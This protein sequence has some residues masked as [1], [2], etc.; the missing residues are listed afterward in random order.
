VAQQERKLFAIGGEEYAWWAPSA[1]TPS[2]RHR[3]DVVVMEDGSAVAS[4][5]CPGFYWHRRCWHA[6]QAVAMVQDR[7][8]VRAHNERRRSMTQQMTVV[9]RNSVQ[10]APPRPQFTP[11]QVDLIKRT[12]AKD[13]D[14]DELALFLTYCNRTGLDP[15]A[16]QIYAIKRWDAKAKR[17][18]MAIQTS[19]DGLRLL[20]ERTGHYAG[21]VGPWWCGPDGQWLDVWLDDDTSPMAA[22]VGV[23][24]DDFREP[25][26]AVA[27]LKA[28]RQTNREGNPTPL[29]GR[30]PDVMLAKCAET[31]ALRRAFPAEMSGLYTTEEMGQATSGY[32]DH[33]TGEMVDAPPARASRRDEAPAA[34]QRPPWVGELASLMNEAGLHMAAFERELGAPPTT[35]ALFV[36]LVELW[37]A[38]NKGQS[39]ADLVEAVLAGDT[40]ED[41]APERSEP[42]PFES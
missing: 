3:V 31:L 25:L 18:V 9:E 28:Y 42:L 4:C 16:R 20:A 23:L 33:E 14:D 6:E 27:T 40:G 24:R 36:N 13:A 12:I 10:V 41:A 32:I 35:K 17:E 15:F 1:S 19:V 8:E 29:W 30:M 38:R 11:E 34:S 37:L 5:D 7:A 26:Y 39:I 2:A 22:R 21:Q